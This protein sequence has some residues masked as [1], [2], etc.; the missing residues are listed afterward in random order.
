M[1]RPA[2]FLDRDD[3]LIENDSLPPESW[4]GGRRGDL[5]DHRFVVPF[6]GAVQ[7]CRDLAA[8]GFMLVVV[9]NQ[10]LVARGHGTLD[11]VE[12]TNAAMRRTFTDPQGRG[13]LAAVYHCPWHPLGTVPGFT[14]EHPW[15][16][17]APGMLLAAAATFGLDLSRSW[18]IGDKDRDLEAGR[19][20][21]LSEDRLILVS[22]RF[23]LLE[24]ARLI[25]GE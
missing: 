1:P 3:T 24:A 17:P 7:A 21:G 13:L 4:A 8:A 10:G 12:A 5:C 2:I 6:P 22:A 11:Q 14:R 20:A 15:R 19:R 23:T 9:S 16:K 25:L 18:A